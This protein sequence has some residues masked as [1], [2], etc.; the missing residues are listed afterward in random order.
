MQPAGDRETDLEMSAVR[1][2]NKA[3]G[4]RLELDGLHTLD[5]R[6]GD[7]GEGVGPGPLEV[8]RPRGARASTLTG[9]VFERSG[10]PPGYLIERRFIAP[11][12]A[13]PTD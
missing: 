4:N 11:V 9:S 6:P 5:D 12:A 10:V 2:A 3:L 1:V 7:D 8:R 13:R